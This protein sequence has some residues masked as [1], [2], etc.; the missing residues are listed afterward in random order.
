MI[1]I[2]PMELEKFIKDTL[3]SI[4]KCRQNITRN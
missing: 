4:K 2:K 3:V 1:V